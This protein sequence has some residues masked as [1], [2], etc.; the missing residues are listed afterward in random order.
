MS[1][2]IKIF[3]FAFLTPLILFSQKDSI[4]TIILQRV[5][6]SGD[7]LEKIIKPNKKFRI[8]TNDDNFYWPKKLVLASDSSLVANNDTILFKNIKSI[9]AK[10]KGSSTA[11]IIFIVA[12]SVILTRALL[13]MIDRYGGSDNLNELEA[14]E[15]NM[16]KNKNLAKFGSS[17]LAGGLIIPRAINF[18]TETK[19]K[20]KT[21]NYSVK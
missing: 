10:F 13:G 4:P 6:N 5:I 20:M 3:L 8:L 18:N 12:G 7:T 15:K 9:R 21:G 16:N 2:L 11:K 1:K 19:W 14:Y 17:I